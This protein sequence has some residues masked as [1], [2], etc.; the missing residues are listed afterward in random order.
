MT[1]ELDPQTLAVTTGRGDQHGALAP[2][3]WS[4]TTFAFDRVED[5]SRKATTPRVRDLYGRYGNPTVA[6]FEE[7]VA[8]L[9]G[10]EASLA[11]SSGM[12]AITTVLLTLL[13][14]GDHAVFGRQLYA[15]TVRTVH[16]LLP[17]LGVDVTVV[18]VTDTAAIEA[19]VV[20]GRTM[21][22]FIESPANPLCQLADL[23][24][25]AAIKGPIKVCDATFATPMV[26]RPLDFGFDLSLHSAT[27]G[28][29]GHNDA[30]LGVVSGSVELI[31]WIW[32]YHSFIGAS[33]SPAEAQNALRGLRT[34]G[35]RLRQQTET[36][37]RLATLFEGH[38]AVAR[39]HYPGLDSHPQADIARRQLH[40][41]G[42]V[43]AVELAG[44]LDAGRRLCED[45]AIPM[46]APS[47][48]GPET[49]LSHPASMTHVDL[50]PEQRAE[51]G[52]ADGLV[53]ISVGLEHPDDLVA[54]FERV[55][56]AL[57]A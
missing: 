37:T 45:A 12:G 54:D 26:C 28:L 57:G 32:G 18:D 53:R 31:T 14:Q 34:L 42:A 7:T 29:G 41:G 47:L 16:D 49:L 43:L 23:E 3:L 1:D 11:F 46:L 25:I 17:R 38:T 30:L 5:A 24:A 33:A 21:A 6:A 8:A 48:G 13:K 2:V 35:V 40:M 20:P 52:I 36:A 15:S 39:V 44:G 50:T 55:L 27:K 51:A 22:I 19:A 9:E 10:A 4:T 56:R